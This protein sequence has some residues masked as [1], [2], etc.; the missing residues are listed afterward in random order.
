M[1]KRKIAQL[2]CEGLVA[3]YDD[4]RLFTLTAL[5]RRGFPPQAINN[6]VK[7]LGLTGALAQLDPLML[8]ACVR[9]E[10]NVNAERVMAVLVPVRVTVSIKSRSDSILLLVHYY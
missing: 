6:F 9:D 10:L 1:S 8:E 7:K 3:D 2:I 4:P 5:R